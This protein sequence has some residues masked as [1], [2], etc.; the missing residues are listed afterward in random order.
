MGA[1]GP[2]GPPE[3]AGMGRTMYSSEFCS[4]FTRISTKSR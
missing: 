1:G 3:L 4:Q 2:P